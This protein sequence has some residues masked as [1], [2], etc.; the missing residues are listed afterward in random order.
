MLGFGK[1]GKKSKPAKKSA[2][3]SRGPGVIARLAG[4]LAGTLGGVR[5]SMGSWATIA[6]RTLAVL[7]FVGLGVAWVAGRDELQRRAAALTVPVQEIRFNWPVAVQM[8][9]SRSTPDPRETWLPAPVRNELVQI[10]SQH[11][12]TGPFE[13][14]P[15]ENIRR[16]LM[17]TGW[18]AS[19]RS[20]SR[21]S[22]G[23]INIMGEWR[24]PTAVV[25]R[26]NRDYLV[27]RGGE[28]LRLPA[29][30]PV[31]PGT[32]PVITSPHL[33]PPQDDG[34][35]SYGKQWAGG[36]VQAALDL[37][38]TVG[39]MPEA[40]RLRGVDLA[41]FMD[42]GHLVLVTD[43]GSR[44]VWGSAIGESALGEAPVDKRR[45]RLKTILAQRFDVEQPNI[46]IY[47]PVVMVDKTN[48]EP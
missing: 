9:E 29:R 19:L 42:K 1:S 28:V 13:R 8:G 44:I 10:A 17:A 46:A 38:R 14:E 2:A 5:A 30:T 23:N 36:D 32:L 31:A 34:V 41:A 43:A 4:S 24:I 37:L 33:P 45:N 18:F 7:T 6:G 27:A 22:A 26:D 16:D 39:G 12:G 25:R 47:T 20:V 21:D 15:L 3:K 40:R 48:S 35:L 11:V